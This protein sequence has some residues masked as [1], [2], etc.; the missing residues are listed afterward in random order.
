M[1]T[2]QNGLKHEK[3]KVKKNYQMIPP[4]TPPPPQIPLTHTQWAKSWGFVE[5]KMAANENTRPQNNKKTNCLKKF[6][7]FPQEGGRGGGTS[8]WKI[9]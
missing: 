5:F 7:Y 1:K 3:K 9:P 2:I 4:P 8:Q 6:N